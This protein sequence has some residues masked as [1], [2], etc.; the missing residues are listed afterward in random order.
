MTD[1]SATT[2]AQ[3]SIGTLIAL[4]PSPAYVR[5]AYGGLGRC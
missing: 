3:R 4:S 2:D 5:S 1:T